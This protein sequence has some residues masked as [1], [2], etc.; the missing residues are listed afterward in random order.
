MKEV[1]VV[2]ICT[3]LVYHC[4]AQGTVDSIVND[5][6]QAAFGGGGGGGAPTSAFGGLGGVTFAPGGVGQIPAS[7]TASGGIA[8]FPTPGGSGAAAAL[9]RF[10]Q[11]NAPA[12]TALLNDRSSRASF[13][14]RTI[15][16]NPEIGG[17]T[18]AGFQRAVSDPEVTASFQRAFD[19]FCFERPV[20]DVS[21]PYRRTDGQCNNLIDPILGAA[22]TP[23]QRVLPAAYD[24]LINT[25]RVR[26]VRPGAFLPSA[27]TVSNNVFQFTFGGMTPVSAAFS[28]YLTHHGQFIDHDV[29]ATPSEQLTVNDCC[30]P[31]MNQQNPEACFSIIIQ[32]GDPFFPPDK[33]CMNVVRHAGSP[34]IRCENGVR[35]QINQRTAFVDGSMIYDSDVTKELQL[36]ARVGG[37]MAENEQNLLPPHPQGCPPLVPPA[38]RQCFVAGDH[39]PSETPTLTIPHITWLRRHNLIADALRLATGITDDETLFQEAKRIVI[40]ELQHVTY[41]EF[42]PAVLD[43][44]HMNAFNLRSRP[45]GHAETYNP[46]LDPRT[47]NAFGV[48]A[49]RMGHSLVRNTVGHV[50]GDGASFS[51]PVHRHFERPDLM[52]DRGYEFMTRWMS[53]EPKSR[54]DRFLVDGIRNRLFEFPPGNQPTTETSSFDLGALN[55]QRGRDHG[56]PSYNAYRQ[57]C[58]LRRAVFFATVPGGLVDHSPQAAAALQQSYLEPDDIDLFAGGLSETPRPG[59]I[60]GPTFQCLIAL[61][62]SLYKHGDRF[63]YERTFPENPL[64]AFTP[65]QLAQIKQTT[66][67]KILCSVVK[68]IPGAIHS[69]QPSL[70]IR[71]DIPGNSLQPCPALL[72]G[73]RLGFDIRPFAQQLLALGGRRRRMALMPSPL[74]PGMMGMLPTFNR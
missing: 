20:C 49:Y 36:R 28:T 58:G 3:A 54:S 4:D 30:M 25:P 71:P 57:F 69:F 40:A 5:A 10:S 37:R 70:M 55:I 31:M 16:Q 62:F 12:T 35:E 68:D 13:A 43:D 52:Y 50:L 44:F 65:A 2:F 67:S 7:R 61:Q 8:P 51:F 53:R 26:S 15:A 60:L 6:V 34:P 27:R 64:A 14:S 39:R 63:W 11:S 32:P 66:Y 47:I 17:G 29:I 42:L 73:T 23:Q 19:P 22:Q 21:E 48:A 33:T 24:N 41:N 59:S 45:F 72:G 46:R 9:A 74:N 38:Q 56:I 18:A 1:Y